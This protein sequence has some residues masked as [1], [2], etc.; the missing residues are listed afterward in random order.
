MQLALQLHHIDIEFRQLKRCLIFNLNMRKKFAFN[1][2]WHLPRQVY[3]NNIF[4]CCAFGLEIAGEALLVIDST[5]TSDSLIIFSSPPTNTFQ[6]LLK[7][8][9]EA[10]FCH[11]YYMNI[12]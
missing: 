12:R 10:H 1:C 2:S 6:W 8:V 3:M 5:S 11:H 4:S 9:I 7:N